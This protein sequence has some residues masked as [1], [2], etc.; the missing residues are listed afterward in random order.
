MD[1]QGPAWPGRGDSMDDDR[2][3]FSTFKPISENTTASTKPA[4]V[5]TPVQPQGHH[6]THGRVPPGS[7]AALP[8]WSLLGGDL[9]PE[10][11]ALRAQTR[12]WF[13][14]TQARRLGAK[15]ELPTWFHG[16]ISRRETEQLLQDQPPGCFLVRFSES[17][18]GFVLSYRGRERCRH[19]VL[20]QWPDGRYVILGEQSAHTELTDLLRHYA[21]APIMPYHEFLTVPCRREDEP[22][23][24][25]RC[26]AGS[27]SARSPS[28]EAPANL[29]AYSIVSRGPPG[30][31]QAAA[32]P[33]PEEGSSREAAG[34]PPPL[35]AKASSLAAAQG[36]HSP[37]GSGA[38]PEGPYAQVHKEAVLPEAPAQPQSADAKYQQLMCFHIYAEPHEGIAPSPSAYYEVE[39][40]I[41]FYATGRGSS[42]SSEENVYSEVALARQDLPAPLPRGARGAFSTLPPKP[43]AHRQLFR[44]ASSQASKKR[45]LPAAPTAVGKE[46]GGSSPAMEV[47]QGPTT[48]PRLEFDNPVDSRRTSGTKRAT[49]AAG[50]ESPENIYEQLSGD[51]L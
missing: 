33:P 43:R 48:N 38:A 21:A 24:G 28:S 5:L 18:V 37:S 36:P 49:T 44:S 13:E 40:P 47:P 14:Q 17:T 51:R 2:P 27:D 22:Q 10:V 4:P 1:P 45:Q 30:A 23:G 12:L 20:D 6:A 15:G 26:P 34:V 9:R 8:G 16:F 19:F 50:Q 42:P 41:P 11:V 35:P 25:T 39:E 7:G 29:L 32:A 31:R 46:R 3:L